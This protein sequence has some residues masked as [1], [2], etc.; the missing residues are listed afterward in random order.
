MI[1]TNPIFYNHS[2][3]CNPYIRDAIASITFDGRSVQAPPSVIYPLKQLPSE[4]STTVT[5]N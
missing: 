5:R 1:F 3:S 2:T 4:S